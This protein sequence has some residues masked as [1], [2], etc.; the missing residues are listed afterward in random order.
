MRIA[1]LKMSKC[2]YKSNVLHLFIII[3]LVITILSSNPYAYSYKYKLITLETPLNN[4][5]LI[6]HY[7]GRRKIS[8]KNLKG[9]RKTLKRS[10]KATSRQKKSL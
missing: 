2:V 3:T 9:F 8:K 7:A 10:V 1:A 5:A 6:I 4:R